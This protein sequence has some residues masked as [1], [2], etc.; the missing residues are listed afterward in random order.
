MTCREIDIPAKQI[1]QVSLQTLSGFMKGVW[2]RDYM[3]IYLYLPYNRTSHYTISLYLLYNWYFSHIYPYTYFYHIIGMSLHT[4]IHIYIYH[5]IGMSLHI[6]IHVYHN[7]GMSLHTYIHIYIYTPYYWY[8]SAY[9]YNIHI[10]TII[11]VCL[12]IYTYI[13]HTYIHIYIYIY[14]NIG[15]SLHIYIH[16]STIILVCLCIHYI[17]YFSQSKRG[18]M[19]VGVIMGAGLKVK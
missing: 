16:M 7:I 4:Y 18:I 17:Q 2:L 12:Y 10:S 13:L 1:V 8:V 6:Y 19:E 15:M 11:L 3:Y 9:I 5:N 14:H